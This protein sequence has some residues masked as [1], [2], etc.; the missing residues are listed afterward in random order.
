MSDRSYS[1]PSLPGRLPLCAG[2][3]LALRARGRPPVHSVDPYSYLVRVPA[4]GLSGKVLLKQKT[5]VLTARRPAVSSEQ[6][7]TPSR[8]ASGKSLPLGYPPVEP[9]HTT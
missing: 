2:E 8:A 6:N 5:L 4:G 3:A 9:V 1:Q 7:G